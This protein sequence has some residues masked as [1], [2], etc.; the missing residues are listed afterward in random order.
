M[1]YRIFTLLLGFLLSVSISAQTKNEKEK[2]IKKSEFPKGANLLLNAIP[3]Q[4]KRIRFYKETDGDKTSFETKFKFKKHWYSVEC[5]SLGKL[6]DIEIQ[7]KEDELPEET[8]DV[9]EDYFEDNS[10]K[11]DIIKIQEQF[12][13]SSK[14]SDTEFLKHISSNRESLRPNYEI[15]VALKIDKVWVLKEITFSHQGQFL[16]ERT[17]KPDSYEYIMY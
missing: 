9:I 2:R 6:E 16:S 7:I 11:Y 10:E 13:Y 1:K 15:I 17:I 3:Q 8:D 4:A 5:D 12:I 14:P